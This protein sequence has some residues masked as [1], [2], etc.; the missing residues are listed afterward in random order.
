MTDLVDVAG[1]FACV[2]PATVLGSDD[3]LARDISD[4]VT[5]W[6]GTYNGSSMT[7]LADVAGTLVRVD[8]TGTL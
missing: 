7:D 4:W 6:M 3:T 1:T 8:P 2:E 5:G